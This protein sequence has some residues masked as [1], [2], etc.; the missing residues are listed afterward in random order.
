M[1]HAAGSPAAERVCQMSDP[2]LGI[3][4]PPGGVGLIHRHEQA[5]EPGIG[6]FHQEAR[7]AHGSALGVQSAGG[8]HHR[9]TLLATQVSRP[10]LPHH[11]PHSFGHTD[12]YLEHLTIPGGQSG[13]PT[14]LVGL[15]R[16]GTRLPPAAANCR[17]PLS[18]HLP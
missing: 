9:P 8:L 1:G 16:H 3:E 11:Q 13:Q 14:G 15:G 7:K 4:R 10:N 5:L 12:E 2:L 6:T 18:E 17:K